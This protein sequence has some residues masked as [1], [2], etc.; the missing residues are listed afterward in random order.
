MG[1]DRADRRELTYPFP[2]PKGTRGY[3]RGQNQFGNNLAKWPPDLSNPPTIAPEAPMLRQ[4][5]ES[6]NAYLE[7]SC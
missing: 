2:T 5:R 3:R 4:F 6:N 7:D 1:R